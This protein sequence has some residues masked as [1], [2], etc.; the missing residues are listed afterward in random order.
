M[1]SLSAVSPEITITATP[2]WPSAARMASSS[3]RGIWGIL[4]HRIC[5][6]SLG[7]EGCSMWRARRIIVDRE[8]VRLGNGGA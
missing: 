3:T 5:A 6:A 4:L 2:R 1:A 7:S 8:D